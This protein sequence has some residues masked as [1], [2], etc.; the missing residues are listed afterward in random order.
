MAPRA[1]CALCGAVR[2]GSGLP[3]RPVRGEK[4]A[5]E[6]RDRGRGFCRCVLRADVPDQ[7]RD[8]RRDT[9]RAGRS[10]L[11]R[12]HVGVFRAVLRD[13]LPRKAKKQTFGGGGVCPVRRADAVLG[14][15]RDHEMVLSVF[16]KKSG[17]ARNGKGDRDDGK[18]VG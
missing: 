4:E 11:M 18:N 12:T 14:K 17:A 3:D 6:K 2:A 15:R 8:P 1:V 10:D 9:G 16:R 13:P 5:P 7:Q